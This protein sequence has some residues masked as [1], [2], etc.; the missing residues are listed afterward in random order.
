MNASSTLAEALRALGRSE[1][2]QTACDE[3]TAIADK[4]PDTSPEFLVE[5]LVVRATLA[6]DRG[7]ADEAALLAER[8]IAVAEK[9]TTHLYDFSKA[10]LVLGRALAQAK[11]DVP[12][13]HAL[14][15]Q[16]RDGFRKLGDR[17]R[18]DEA[19]SA[20]AAMH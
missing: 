12:R 10:R 2:A 6:L 16:A 13:A 5:L 17:L 15:E 18:I 19:S 20:L 1:E 7:K 11:R 14:A 8:A 3:A 9:G 4:N